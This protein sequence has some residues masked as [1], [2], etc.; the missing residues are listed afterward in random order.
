MFC[1]TQPAQAQEQERAREAEHTARCDREDALVARA[2]DTDGAGEQGQA[3]S[4]RPK[5]RVLLGS[6]IMTIEPLRLGS[7]Y[8]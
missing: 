4:R 8:V 7:L 2:G 1:V 3:R 6:I 5:P